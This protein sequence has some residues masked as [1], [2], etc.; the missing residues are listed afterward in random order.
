MPTLVCN[1]RTAANGSSNRVLNYSEFRTGLTFREVWE[2]LV[3]RKY[4]RRNGVL[5]KWY[6]LKQAMYRDYIKGFD[7]PPF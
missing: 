5:G 2:M 6:E 4:R 7:Q 3:D 1:A